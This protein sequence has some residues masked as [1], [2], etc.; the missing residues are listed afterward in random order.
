MNHNI[1]TYDCSS[2]GAEWQ[3]AMDKRTVSLVPSSLSSG[4]ISIMLVLDIAN[5]RFVFLKPLH[6]VV[7]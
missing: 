1:I 2:C 4:A 3:T 6:L 7:S 5:I